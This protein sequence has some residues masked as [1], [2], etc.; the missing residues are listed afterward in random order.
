MDLSGKQMLN[1]DKSTIVVWKH[2]I[3]LFNILD[4]YYFINNIFLIH[5]IWYRT[6]S[7]LTTSDKKNIM[8]TL[9]T[10]IILICTIYFITFINI[11]LFLKF[12]MHCTYVK[13]R[14]RF[15]CTS[16][17]VLAEHFKLHISLLKIITLSLL[18]IFSKSFPK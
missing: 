17:C 14:K 16:T 9:I 8:H 13:L 11:K 18:K 10:F 3:A 5:Y 2:L 1:V 4:T 6:T 15:A 12:Y 7:W